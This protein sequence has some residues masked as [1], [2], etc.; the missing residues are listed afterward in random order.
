MFIYSLLLILVVQANSYLNFENV[1]T[2]ELTKKNNLILRGSVDEESVSNIIYEINKVY[3][4]SSIYLFLDTPG[5]EV[6][7]GLQLINEIK[8]NNI[9]CIAQKAYSMGFAILQACKRR[10]ILP[11]SS[12][13]QH[14]ISFGIGGELGKIKAH[15]LLVDQYNSFLIEMQ[16]KRIHMHPQ[17]FVNK[18]NNEW[19]LFGG[20]II[21]ENVADEMIY[22]SCNNGLTNT[23]Y[24]IS[25]GAYDYTYSSCPLISKELHKKKNKKTDDSFIYF[26]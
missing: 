18:I 17:T 2:I 24:T 13:M 19:W 5:G 20:N 23:N 14:Q 21:F 12:V 3:N 1:D 6:T 22:A 26:M 8:K 4:K 10:Y 7:Y 25:K 15:T 16:S 11:H 9:S